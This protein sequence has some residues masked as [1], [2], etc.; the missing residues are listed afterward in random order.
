MIMRI[1]TS[2]A[3]RFIAALVVIFDNRVYCNVLFVHLIL[4]SVV[5]YLSV[6]VGDD[7][8]HYFCYI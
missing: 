3:E 8:V 7:C 4:N 2:G 1:T 6:C 5:L